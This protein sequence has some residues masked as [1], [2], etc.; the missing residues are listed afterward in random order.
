MKWLL[1]NVRRRAAFALRNP[2]YVANSILRELA[3]ADEK[4]IGHITG[5]SSA[6]IRAYMDEPIATAA[7]ANVLKTAEEEIGKLSTTSADLFAKKV[8]L[9]YVAVRALV[10]ECI[11]ET[12]IA[13]GVSSAYILLAIQKNGKGKLHSIELG[14]TTLLPTGAEPGWL[15]PAWLRAPWQVHIGD[16]R[17]LLPPLLSQCRQVDMFIHDSLHTYDHMLWEYEA[18]YPALRSGG[19]LLSDDALWNGAFSDFASKVHEPDWR[20]LRGVGFLRKSK[21]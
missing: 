1:Q 13:N 17:Q 9:Q 5:T 14:D 20:I 3:Q 16:T 12:G 7:F 8:L 2:R 21:G 10:P 19:L 4:F 18:A 11:V 6:Q 15:V